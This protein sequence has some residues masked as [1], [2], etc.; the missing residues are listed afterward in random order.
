MKRVT[1]FLQEPWIISLS[2]S[3]E[4]FIVVSISDMS[5]IK[6]WQNLGNMMGKAKEKIP[7]KLRIGDTCFTSLETIGG[8]LLTRH[9]KNINHVHKESNDILSV[10]I[11]LGTD[12]HGGK[13]VFMMDMK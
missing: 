2:K 3:A 11:F 13:T 5:A 12:V 8:N 7:K 9:P 10:I 1:I 4:T 6:Y